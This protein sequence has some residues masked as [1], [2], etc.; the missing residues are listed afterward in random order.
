M[1]DEAENLVRPVRCFFC[2]KPMFYSGDERHVPEV[3]V[4]IFKEGGYSIDSEFYA[5]QTCWNKEM[6][7]WMTR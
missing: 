4:E 2:R 6:G 7:I 5:H 1:S 3:R